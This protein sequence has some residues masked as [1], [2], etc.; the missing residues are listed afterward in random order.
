MSICFLPLFLGLIWFRGRGIGLSTVNDLWAQREMLARVFKSRSL[1]RRSIIGDG[2]SLFM[3]LLLNKADYMD[4]ALGF[5]S[6]SFDDEQ[7]QK[8]EDGRKSLGTERTVGAEGKEMNS[9]RINHS[10]FGR[11]GWCASLAGSGSRDVP[12]SG[13]GDATEECGGSHCHARSER[14]RL[15]AQV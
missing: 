8:E 11:S 13:R 10:H 5:P 15:S 4:V 12:S 3:L 9:I 14:S 6:S 7:Q 1:V 2:I